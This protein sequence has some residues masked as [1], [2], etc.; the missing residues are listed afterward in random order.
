M[1]VLPATDRKWQAGGKQGEE[2]TAGVQIG[3]YS[4]GLEVDVQVRDV[5]LDQSV[6]LV[7]AQPQL[8][9]AG[10]EH[11]PHPVIL[12]DLHHH[13]EALLLWHLKLEQSVN[14]EDFSFL[15]IV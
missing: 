4:L 10:L 7:H 2:P 5:L 12:H 15:L 1:F 9:H 14:R 8:R 13:C 6:Q 3:V 11:L